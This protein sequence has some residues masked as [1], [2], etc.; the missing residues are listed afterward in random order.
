[1]SVNLPTMQK[2]TEELD[3]LGDWLW[4]DE[5]FGK[6]TQ[7]SCALFAKHKD[8][9]LAL[10]NLSASFVDRISNT[11][12]KKDNVNKHQRSDMQHRR[13]RLPVCVSF[14]EVAYMLAMVEIPFT[15]YLAVLD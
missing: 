12:L 10:R 6:V 4:Y 15:K 7:I 14:F 11:A 13:S 1:M 5:L 8:R 3:S 9:L 2:W